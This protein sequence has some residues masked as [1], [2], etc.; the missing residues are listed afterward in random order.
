MIDRIRQVINYSQLSSAAFADTIGISRSGLTHLLTGRN[1]PSLDVSRKILAKFPEISTEWLIMGM[2]EMLRPDEQPASS[3]GNVETE[4]TNSS[5]SVENS[6]FDRQID[7]FGEFENP[8]NSETDTQ[9]DIEIVEDNKVLEAEPKN[10]EENVEAAAESH[11]SVVESPVEVP[12]QA[13]PQ[14]RK[15]QD[16]RQFTPSKRD[17]RQPNTAPERKLQKIVFFY[18]DH[19]FEVFSNC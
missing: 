16:S 13:Q 9:D 10:I 7:L 6:K 12:Q 3:S 4:T 15:A 18:D 14:V 2:G 19:S 1:Q 17:R 5:Q 11:P 8:A